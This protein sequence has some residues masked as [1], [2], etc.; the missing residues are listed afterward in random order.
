MLHDGEMRRSE[1]ELG[2][3]MMR[4]TSAALW[5]DRAAAADMLIAWYMQWKLAVECR[6]G[7]KQSV[8]DIRCTNG[9]GG[10]GWDGATGW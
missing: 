9:R 6:L 2:E 4:G 8:W 1:D 7:A 3:L 10:S 5:S